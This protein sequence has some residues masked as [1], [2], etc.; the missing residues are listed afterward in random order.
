MSFSFSYAGVV[1]EA[2]CKVATRGGASAVDIATK[3]VMTIY[4]VFP[5]RIG[6][7]P[8]FKFPGLEDFS[9]LSNIPICFCLKPPSPVPVPG[10]KISL[11]EPIALVETTALP[12]CM[13]TFGISIPVDIGI[14]TMSIGAIDTDIDHHTLNTYQ[15][16]Y[17]KYP[18]FKLLNMLMDFVCLEMDGGL[19][20]AYF[21]E[22]DPLWQNDTWT[23]ILNPEV[24]LVSNPIA[25]MACIADSISASLG[26]PLDPL[27][28]CFGAWG[29][30]FPMTQ[31]VEG[32]NTVEASAN[33]TARL[34]MK[35]HR[36]LLLWGSVGEA[37]LCQKFPMPIM[38]KSQYGIFPIYPI[39]YP[40]RIPIGRT[41]FLWAEGQDVPFANLHTWVWNIYRKRDC[42]AF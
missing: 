23:A 30:A 37:G 14:G 40:L 32:T 18:V 41:G 21:T 13:P 27:W 20:L 9:E 31:N 34:L 1:T 2:Q 33:I 28:W 8:L 29:S 25:Q 38:R 16:H 7:V 26:F 42:C 5:I 19:D 10:I 12:L 36:Q 39:G 4:N 11:W 24:F 6:N 17:I 22:V 15:A 3:A 35:M